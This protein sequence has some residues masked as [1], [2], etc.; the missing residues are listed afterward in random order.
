[1]L[2]I[3]CMNHSELH[4]VPQNNYLHSSYENVSQ[5]H[6]RQLT[7]TASDPRLYVLLLLN[8]AYYLKTSQKKAW[9]KH[10]QDANLSVS[11]SGDDILLYVQAHN[12]YFQS[13]PQISVHTS[14]TSEGSKACTLQLP[15]VQDP[16]LSQVPSSL[17]RFHGHPMF[18][19]IQCVL[20]RER[21]I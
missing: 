6:V 11:D 8:G 13:S 4:V 19:S 9:T 5:G 1:M 20:M 7:W 21:L 3:I 2:H 17:S 16:F 18:R 15:C 10:Q 14:T 12:T